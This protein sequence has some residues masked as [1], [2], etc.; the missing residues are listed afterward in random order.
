MER[1]KLIQS[2]IHLFSDIHQMKWKAL[3][4]GS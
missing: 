1:N 3:M 4:H 2:K